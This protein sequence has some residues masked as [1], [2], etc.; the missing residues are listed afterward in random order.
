MPESFVLALISLRLPDLPGAVLLETLRL[1][2]PDLPIVC[3]DDASAALADDPP[4]LSKPIQ[5]GTFNSQVVEAMER[6]TVLP[7][8]AVLPAESIARAKAS[9]AVSGSLLDAARELSRGNLLEGP[10]DEPPQL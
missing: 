8:L 7:D 4:C 3:L 5:Q 1:F 2:R 10:D 6:R 9:F